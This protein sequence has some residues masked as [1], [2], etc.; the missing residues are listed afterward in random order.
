MGIRRELGVKEWSQSQFVTRRSTLCNPLKC[1]L[2]CC[3]GGYRKTC[4]YDCVACVSVS[5]RVKMGT[6]HPSFHTSSTP[7]P[8]LGCTY[9]REHLDG[10]LTAIPA[11][12]AHGTCSPAI[13]SDP[14]TWLTA[15]VVLLQCLTLVPLEPPEAIHSHLPHL[16]PFSFGACV[17][18]CL[19]SVVLKLRIAEWGQLATVRRVDLSGCSRWATPCLSNL[20]CFS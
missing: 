11:V 12:A 9:F 15:P 8:Q 17:L 13:V 18:Y 19:G 14:R 1:V 3:L 16:C 4:V 5:L 6:H 7:Y 20:S 2:G 10:Q